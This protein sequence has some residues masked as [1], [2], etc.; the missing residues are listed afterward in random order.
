MLYEIA[1][2]TVKIDSFGTAKQR[3]EK[4]LCDSSK[5][6]DF[7]LISPWKRSKYLHPGVS[8]D[9]G[10][11][12]S[13]GTL[14]YERL[15][16]FDGIMLHSSAVVIGSKAYLFTADSG[17]GKSTHTALWRKLFGEKAIILNDDKP[18]LRFKDGKWFAYGTPWSGK[19]DFS[20]NMK[21]EVAG[22]AILKRA[23]TNSIKRVFGV[24]AISAILKQVNRPKNE[25]AR[26][27]VLELL[28][29]LILNVPI[30]ELNCNTELEAAKISYE[31]MSQ[32]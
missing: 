22:I 4:Y 13:L 9:I 21:V 31:A 29:K 12:M 24:E 30:W 14:F 18:A 23:E 32:F 2:L 15:L 10:E 20:V 1:D 5:E 27:K 26:S 11:Y 16:K 25:I 8:D 3:L 6:F 7:E 19:N 17:T 28:D